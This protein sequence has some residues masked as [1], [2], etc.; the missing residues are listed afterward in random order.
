MLVNIYFQK[1]NIDNRALDTGFKEVENIIDI[2]SKHSDIMLPHIQLATQS[3]S[4]IILKLMIRRHNVER[5]EEIMINYT[6][7]NILKIK[8]FYILSDD[9]SLFV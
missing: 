7:I 8:K 2:I 3:G 9:T 5:V 1:I 4:N 6:P